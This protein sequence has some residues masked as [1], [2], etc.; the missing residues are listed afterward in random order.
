MKIEGYGYEWDA[1][2]NGGPADGCFDIVIQLN[3]KNP[4]KFIKR[5]V[6]G[7]EIERESLG[8]KLIEYLA[9]NNLDENQKIA[10]YQLDRVEENEKETCFYDY[11]ETTTMKKFREN[12]EIFN[13][14]IF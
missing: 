2:L 7:E 10:V 14:D 5:I 3:K 4:P 1:K 8:E 9:K 6:D 12:Y 11:V 13:D